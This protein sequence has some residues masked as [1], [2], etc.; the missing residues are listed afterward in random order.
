MIRVHRSDLVEARLPI[1]HDP[2]GMVV[3][4]IAD[5]LEHRAGQRR[6]RHFARAAPGIVGWMLA[7]ERA[8]AA[9]AELASRR[10]VLPLEYDSAH[11]L[12][13]GRMAQ[14]IEYDLRH[15]TLA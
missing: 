6:R 9:E 5:L 3:R 12:R 2:V 10:T 13:K 11:G 8:V 7:G 15:R 1:R 4:G 14:A